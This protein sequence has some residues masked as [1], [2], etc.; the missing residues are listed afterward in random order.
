MNHSKLLMVFAVLTTTM[1]IASG[2]VTDN[3]FDITSYG[4]KGNGMTVNTKAIN[5]AIE[6]C[7][8]TGGGQVII[9]KGVFMSGT[10]HMKDNVNLYLEEGAVLKG[11]DDLTAYDSYIPIG[12]MKKYHSAYRPQWNRG[13]ILAVGTSNTSISGK[14]TIDGGHIADPQGEEKMRGPHAVLFGECRNFEISGITVN[15]ASNYAFMSYALE[16]ATFH[17]LTINE[18]WDG[19]HVRGGKNITIR[20][21]KFNTGDDAIAGG[22]WNDMVITDCSINSS[23]N[24]IRVIMPVEG[25]EIGKC[26]F[27]GPGK[28]PHRTSG[29][30]KRNNSLSAII[31]QPGGW[32]KSEGPIHNVW[33]HDIDI[34]LYNTPFTMVLNEG[35]DTDNILVERLRAINIVLSGFSVE[36]WKG[37]ISGN[38]TFRD[39]YAEFQGKSD[40]KVKEIKLGQ[41]GAD[42]RAMPYWGFYVNNTRN[43][44]LENVELK[45][46]GTEVRPAM[47]FY[48]TDVV[49]LINVKYMEVP[50]VKGSVFI[51]T[52][53]VNRK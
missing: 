52:G 17:N 12:D 31:I 24:G 45:F 4:A 23:C 36:S 34:D 9:P 27:R 39:I 43:I 37:G 30:R 33:V 47:G 53:M 20:N 40:P 46:T 50:D 10:I 18:G 6:A 32:G 7:E 13:L 29:E 21:C 26:T 16:N 22:F 38:V 15:N 19:I 8:K 44:T 3:V 35:N 28:Y 41:P 42:S 51:N 5:S 48:N 25:L 2:A 49:N 14:G 1:S 11:V